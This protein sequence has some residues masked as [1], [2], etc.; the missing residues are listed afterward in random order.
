MLQMQHRSF[1]IAIVVAIAVM[2]GISLYLFKQDAHY[3]IVALMGGIALLTGVTLLSYFIIR[4][5][6][7]SSNAYAM[8]RAQYTATMIKF[9]ACVAALLIYIFV[10]G[11]VVHKPSLFLFLGMYVVFASIEAI[12]LA[13]IAKNNR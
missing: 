13:R 9:F 10:N 4:K 8:T 6:L 1:I 7:Q 5:G 11:R 2:V 12:T 3:D